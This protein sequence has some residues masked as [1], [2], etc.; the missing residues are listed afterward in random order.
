MTKPEESVT[1]TWAEEDY[2]VSFS[3]LACH[4]FADLRGIFGISKQS[5]VQSLCDKPMESSRFSGGASTAT[6]YR[7]ADQRFLLKSLTKQESVI[8]LDFLPAYKSYMQSHPRS[9][10]P[11]FVGMVVVGLESQKLVVIYVV[12]ENFFA[13]AGRMD[14]VYDLKGSKYKRCCLAADQRKEFKA[15][16]RSAFIMKDVDFRLNQEKLYLVPSD[17]QALISDLKQ[18]SEFLKVHGFM[19]YSLLLGLQRAPP[20]DSVDL[21]RAVSCWMQNLN[22]F[23]LFASHPVGAQ[24]ILH[25]AQSTQEQN[26]INIC[27]LHQAAEGV[28]RHL[29]ATF[30]PSFPSTSVW[31]TLFMVE[32]LVQTFFIP[33]ASQFVAPLSDAHVRRLRRGIDSAS[34]VALDSKVGGNQKGS[35]DYWDNYGEGEVATHQMAPHFQPTQEGQFVATDSAEHHGAALLDQAITTELWKTLRAVVDES[36]ALMHSVMI[37][38]PMKDSSGFLFS[39]PLQI[40]QLELLRASSQAVVVQELRIGAES[41]VATDATE[42]TADAAKRAIEHTSTVGEVGP[43]GTSRIM[44]RDPGDVSPLHLGSD[45]VLQCFPMLAC[46]KNDGP[47]TL[48]TISGDVC[49]VGV[50]DILQMY[51]VKKLVETS[52][53]GIVV[54]KKILSSVPPEPYA[55]R[56]QQL[57]ERIFQSSVDAATPLQ[58]LPQKQRIRKSTK[59][60][61]EP[62]CDS[63]PKQMQNGSST[64]ASTTSNDDVSFDCDD[65]ELS[66]SG[67]QRDRT[68]S[69]SE[70]AWVVSSTVA[71]PVV[72]VVRITGSVVAAAG[73][74]VGKIAGASLSALTGSKGISGDVLPKSQNP[75]AMFSTDGPGVVFD[76]E[77]GVAGGK[78]I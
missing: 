42:G 27:Q 15:T 31:S 17:R 25:Y 51:T 7:S 5:L 30:D 50:V 45:S 48:R 35:D 57:C 40:A 3:D 62:L 10:L 66:D 12:M 8:L 2:L 34:E 69:W 33:S 9:R 78:W 56:W 71:S 47:N 23:K 76:S 63:E 26:L 37:L 61:Q 54:E 19:D 72:G 21:H 73:T 24:A 18:D 22:N 11:K 75:A 13:H 70:W 41:K 28:A 44:R 65:Q 20:T 68:D 53:K 52:L 38:E 36:A 1:M 32:R 39:Q 6:Y 4:H 29:A 77:L 58:K 16:R 64:E 49:I 46:A 55:M 60:Q 59:K 14:A 74:I 43:F 67:L